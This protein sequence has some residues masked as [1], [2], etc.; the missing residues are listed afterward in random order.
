VVLRAG[1]RIVTS[2]SPIVGNEKAF[3]GMMNDFIRKGIEVVTNA[4]MDIHA[5]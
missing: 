1:D 4:D 2:T 3:Y 5:S